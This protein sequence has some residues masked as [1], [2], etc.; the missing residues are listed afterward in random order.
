MI[1]NE[2]LS[3]DAGDSGVVGCGIEGCMCSL[4]VDAGDDEYVEESGEFISSSFCPATISQTA[5]VT[6]A[7]AGMGV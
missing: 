5:G 2:H 3:Q 6:A 4:N 1:P 7:M